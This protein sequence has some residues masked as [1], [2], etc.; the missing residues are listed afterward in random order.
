M[1][2]TGGSGAN[3]YIEQGP[4]QQIVSKIADVVA[5]LRGGKIYYATE[6]WCYCW[7]RLEKLRSDKW[8]L[9]MACLLVD[10]GV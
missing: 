5:I 7:R 10:F 1:E 8:M 2:G 3:V 4:V 6:V 9:L